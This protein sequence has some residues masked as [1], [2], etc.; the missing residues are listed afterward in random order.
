[1]KPLFIYCLIAFLTT[2]FG[3]FLPFYKKAWTQRHLWQLLAF[4]SGVLLGIAFLHLLP[5]AFTLSSRMAG[6]ALL[7]TFAFLFAAENVTMVHACE[8][9]LKPPS[10]H[11]RPVGAIIALALH[12]GV[13][14]MAIGVGLRQNMILGSVISF[15]VILHKFS[16]GMTLMSLLRAAN[17]SQR[18]EWVLS[19]VLALATP[20]G[21]FLSFQCAGPLAP[22]AIAGV[23]GIA[24]GSFLYVGAA[25]LLPRLHESHD[26]Y[27][28][29]FFLLG[30]CTV[31]LMP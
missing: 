4:S 27:C 11:V 2:V 20:V 12:A 18:R 24:A 21:A 23:L 17:Y 14:G 7:G 5:E 6:L 25:D 15:G 26:R 22:K 3:S 19:A 30:I 8:D 16:D 28:L 13:D 10:S 29:V 1:M 9:F 31:G